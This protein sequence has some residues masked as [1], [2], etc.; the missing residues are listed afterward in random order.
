MINPFTEVDWNPDRAAKRRFGLSWLIGFPCVAL[1]LL[2]WSRLR[3]G[4]WEAVWPYWVGGVGAGLGLLFWLLPALAGP[5]YRIWFAFACTMGLVI[6]NTLFALFY[7]LVMT[8]IG[9]F[10]RLIGRSPL[11]R[12]PDPQAA[13][14]WEDAP[15]AKDVRRYYRQY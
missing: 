3:T 8:P 5:F 10:V 1:V 12:R 14:Y 7:Y 11:R 9:L 2:G 15:K 6:G 4:G 13:T